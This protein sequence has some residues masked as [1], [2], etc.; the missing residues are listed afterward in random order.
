MGSE[1]RCSKGWVLPD[2][3]I[4]RP[5]EKL[6][7]ANILSGNRCRYNDIDQEREAGL[8]DSKLEFRSSKLG[9]CFPEKSRRS[10]TTQ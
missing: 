2:G 9:C 1:S 8:R 7:N 6:W 5:L 4:N 3:A 10:R